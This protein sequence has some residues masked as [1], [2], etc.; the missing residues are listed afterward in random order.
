MEPSIEKLAIA[1]NLEFLETTPEPNRNTP[2]YAQ[3]VLRKKDGFSS[4]IQLSIFVA[5]VVWKHLPQALCLK[6]P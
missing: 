6:L 2:S 3:F 1:F 5:F 4:L